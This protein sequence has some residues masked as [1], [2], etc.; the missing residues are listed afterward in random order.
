MEFPHSHF[1]LLKC[2]LTN[3]KSISE[4]TDYKSVG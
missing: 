1:K 4:V 3:I 2:L